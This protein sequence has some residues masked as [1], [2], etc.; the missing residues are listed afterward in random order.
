MTEG[1]NINLST[2]VSGEVIIDKAVELA[3]THIARAILK[4]MLCKTKQSLSHSVE[5]PE[6]YIAAHQIASDIGSLSLSLAYAEY[7]RKTLA[8]ALSAEIREM[9]SPKGAEPRQLEVKDLTGRGFDYVSEN[10]P[11]KG[12]PLV[13]QI[14]SVGE[15]WWHLQTAQGQVHRLFPVSPI[16]GK[17]EVSISLLPEEV[18]TDAG[19]QTIAA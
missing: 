14:V 12:E 1:T 6:D 3:Q 18:A 13:G 7:D 8:P 11:V 19:R 10:P 2:P 5:K 17:R 16:T 15:Y 4:D 9:L